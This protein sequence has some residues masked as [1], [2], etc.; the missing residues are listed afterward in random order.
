MHLLAAMDYALNVNNELN[1]HF[2]VQSIFK[3][4]IEKAAL[5]RAHAVEDKYGI[6]TNLKITFQN[7]S[8]QTVAIDEMGK[9]IRDE[10]EMILIRAGGHGSLLEN[11]MD[12]AEN[13]L[14]FVRNIDNVLPP[15]H[16]TLNVFYEK[17][18]GGYLLKIRD[19][20]FSLLK[21]LEEKD[22]SAYDESILFAEMHLNAFVPIQLKVERNIDE[23][24]QLINRPLR[25]C[26]MIK[27]QGEPGGGPFWIKDKK[28]NI[29]LQI[30]ENAQIDREDILQQ[31]ISES[32]RYFNPVDMVCSIFD[33][34]GKKYDLTKFIDHTASIVSDREYQSNK[35]IVMER[36]GL[37]NGTMAGWHTIFIEIPAN[38]FNPVKTV[39]DL[40]RI[41]AK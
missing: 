38:C 37:W 1:I 25:V 32:A 15:G 5:L 11:F 33:H 13:E 31:K 3:K 9:I 12:V 21:R 8:T 2:T 28:G 36:P 24:F 30:V 29:S 35:I 4:E 17:I 10:N 27:S 20:L 7:P 16:N 26:G 23:L 6:Q 41:S 14:I 39:L 40:L 34:N 19:K 22:D 18:M